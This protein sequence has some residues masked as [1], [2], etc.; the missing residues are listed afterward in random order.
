MGGRIAADETVEQRDPDRCPDPRVRPG[1]LY[2]ADDETTECTAQLLDRM[3][4]PKKK[5]NRNDSPGMSP[6]LSSSDHHSP[7]T[8][9]ITHHTTKHLH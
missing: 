4:L 1:T 7:K 6:F 2:R 5:I 8:N 9:T 3:P